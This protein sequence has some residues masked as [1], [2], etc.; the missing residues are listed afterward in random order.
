M[1]NM[2]ISESKL[3]RIQVEYERKMQRISENNASKFN[4]GFKLIGVLN[5]FEIIPDFV[6]PIFINTQEELVE[7][8]IMNKP[9]YIQVGSF[10]EDTMEYFA[11]LDNYRYISK[12]RIHIFGGI[13]SF[14]RGKYDIKSRPLYAFQYTD[15]DIFWGNYS[16]MK[17]FFKN[18]KTDDEVLQEQIQDFLSLE[19]QHIW[20]RIKR[21]LAINFPNDSESEIDMKI[22]T[23]RN[24]DFE[25]KELE[26][27]IP[28]FH[29]IVFRV[30]VRVKGERKKAY[31][32]TKEG[33]QLKKV[34]ED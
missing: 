10:E 28:K 32:T 24:N 29:D 7:P 16:E 15:K 30:G 17:D 31:F 19:S 3:R 23:L 4:S 26:L 21:E 33:E 18:Y 14:S 6:I 25:G 5:M 12:E 8:N 11:E 20:S 34:L 2:K 27:Y 9:F 1:M 13:D 22:K